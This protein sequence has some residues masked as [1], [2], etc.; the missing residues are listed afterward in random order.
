M[1]LRRFFGAGN[2]RKWRLAFS[3]AHAYL[4]GRKPA[5]RRSLASGIVFIRALRYCVFQAA[6]WILLHY[7]VHDAN[8]NTIHVRFGAFQ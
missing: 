4:V 1:G 8:K 2:K 6:V 3:S 7:D 5:R